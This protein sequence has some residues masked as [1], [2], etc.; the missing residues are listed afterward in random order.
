MSEVLA[1]RELSRQEGPEFSL[2]IPVSEWFNQGRPLQA[3]EE[4][5]ELFLK[6][7]KERWLLI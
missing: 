2:Q 5:G 6:P 1:S 7:G 4:Q 3:G